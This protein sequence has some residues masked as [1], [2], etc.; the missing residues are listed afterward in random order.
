MIEEANNIALLVIEVLNQLDIRYLIG[1]SVASTIHGIPRATLDVDLLADIQDLHLKD[2]YEKLQG[3]F[4]VSDQAVESALKHRSSFNLIHFETSFK[5]DVF[6][7]KGRLF[8]EQQFRNRAL[9]VIARNPEQKAYVAS[10]EDSILTKL[11]WYRQGNEVWERQ[12]T[13]VLGIL[14]V[15]GKNLDN[16]YLKQTATELGI[17]DLLL[18]ALET[19]N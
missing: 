7:P 11:E 17:L 4:Y 12:W 8:D 19:A 1:G 9:Y 18:R 2:F 14:K 16:D 6:L 13:D 3:N 5:V 10:P 15:Q